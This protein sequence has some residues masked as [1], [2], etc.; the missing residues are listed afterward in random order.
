MFERLQ[1]VSP[2]VLMSGGTI[3]PLTEPVRFR[4]TARSRRIAEGERILD[5]QEDLHSFEGLVLNS[6]QSKVQQMARRVQSGDSQPAN[7]LDALVHQR[8]GSI[9][10]LAARAGI[11]Y[12]TAECDL[13]TLDAVGWVSRT[14]SHSGVVKYS[15]LP[16]D[17]G[18]R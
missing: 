14:A 15:L 7:V 6:L 5:Q 17:E 13:V 12:E 16:D 9:A 11:D 4:R 2:G 10:A 18:T 1:D 3:P 8:D